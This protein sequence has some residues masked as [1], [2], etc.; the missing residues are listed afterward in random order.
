VSIGGYDF[1]EVDGQVV[2]DP[3]GKTQG[4]NGAMSPYEQAQVD[5]R[6]RE[7]N[8]QQ[9]QWGTDAI[10][11]QELQNKVNINNAQT[12]QLQRMV[13]MS[14]DNGEAAAIAQRQQMASTYEEWRNRLMSELQSSPRSWI[15]YQELKAK[16]NP[17]AAQPELPEDAQK[18]WD[19]ALKNADADLAD[20]KAAFDAQAA[21]VTDNATIVPSNEVQ[22]SLDRFNQAVEYRNKVADA[23]KAHSETWQPAKAES[24]GIGENMQ[25][26]G[27]EYNPAN[28]PVQGVPVPNWLPNY[29][30]ELNGQPVLT[31]NTVAPLSG[32]ALTRITPT[33]ME[34]LKGYQ[35]WTGQNV[36]DWLQQTQIQMPNAANVAGRWTPKKARY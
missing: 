31:K 22:L 29:V 8:N 7:L 21:R 24:T 6:N 11:N 19:T 12:A 14:N 34:M 9:A 13:G 36:N 10:R 25:V 5:L 30:P 18:K 32:Q 15:N 28:K 17:Y 26:G 35:D 33:N 4:V 23:A 3:I 2:P 1:L 20:A 27:M 16:P